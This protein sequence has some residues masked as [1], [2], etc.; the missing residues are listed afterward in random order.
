MAR[1]ER[2]VEPLERE[3]AHHRPALNAGVSG[4]DASLDVAHTPL[5]ALRHPARSPDQANRG[6]HTGDIVGVQRE[7]GRTGDKGKRGGL[8]VPGRH[9]TDLAHALCKQQIG[10]DGGQPL[11]VDLVDAAELPERLTH[12]GVNLAARE[13]VEREARPREPRF[14]PDR[15]RTIAGMRDPDEV[16]LQAKRAHDLGR[17]GEERGDAS[18]GA[19]RPPKWSSPP[20][21]IVRRRAGKFFTSS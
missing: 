10:P 9:R 17:A 1:H 2:R 4:C 15:W 5:R 8:G 18:G 3:D 12:R 6:E 21:R 20:T 14:A 16:V 11:A 7:H 13:P 19:H